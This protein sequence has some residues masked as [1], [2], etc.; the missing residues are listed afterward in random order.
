MVLVEDL[1]NG[2]FMGQRYAGRQAEFSF[3]TDDI[4]RETVGTEDELTDRVGILRE[5]FD[6]ARTAALENTKLYLSMVS[7]LDVYVATSMRTREHFRRMAAFCDDVFN[8][9]DLADLHLRYFDPTLSAA[10][11]H[12]DKGLIECLM[13]DAAKVLVYYAGDRESMGKDFEAA[14]ALSRGKPVILFCEDEGR[15]RLYREIH[16]LTRLIEFNT[17]VAIGA[18]VTTSIES[19]RTIL[20]R[21]LTNSMRYEVKKTELGS[22]HLLEDIS[23]SLVRL[24]TH[25]TLLQETF[26]NY[27]HRKG[28]LP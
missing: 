4:L 12:V 10:D 21:I 6:R 28:T 3:S 23:R 16:P 11:G 15:E 25:D 24:Q 19:V 9:D 20:G 5:K 7:D 13:V 26:W 1:V 14:M 22:L 8:H 27:Y 17:G 2:Q 18:M